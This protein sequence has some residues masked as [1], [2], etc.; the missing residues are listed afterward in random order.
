[1]LMLVGAGSKAGLVPLHVWLPLAHPAAPSHVS[2]LMSGVMTKVAVYGFIRIV[3]DLLGPVAWWASPVVI[4]LGAVTAVL[5]ILF[6]MM[7]G[8][9]KRVLAY[10]ARSR[11]SASSSSR[12]AWRWRSAPTACR[13]RRRWPSPPRCFTSSTTWLFKS[14]LFMGAGAVLTATGERDL[15]GL[16]GLIHRMPATAFLVLVG[17]TAISALPPLNGFVSEWLLFQAVLLSPELPQSALQLLVP[18]AGGLLAL[19]AALAAACFVRF[20]GVAFLGRPR[21]AGGARRASRSTAF[22]WRRWRCWL[23]SAFLPGIAARGRCSTRWR[24]WSSAMLDGTPAGADRAALALARADRREPQL[25]Q[26]ASGPGLHRLRRVG[27]VLA[28]PSLRLAARCAA[29]P[30]WDCGFPRRRAR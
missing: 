3:F 26:R 30:A 7:D 8:D 15:D 16:G 6:A 12:S 24:R 1:M 21:T 27:C 2:A 18:A 5:G 19:S 20:Y 22:R 13:R 9:L 14:L 29:A 4:L 25:L 23:R 10:S 17:A 11:T 28:G